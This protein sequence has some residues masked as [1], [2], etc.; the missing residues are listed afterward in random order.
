M[1]E[2]RM[3]TIHGCTCGPREYKMATECNKHVFRYNQT[4]ERSKRVAIKALPSR[5][6]GTLNDTWKFSSWPATLNEGSRWLAVCSNG[7]DAFGD[8][9]EAQLNERQLLGSTAASQ[10]LGRRVSTH[11]H[12]LSP[13]ALPS[14]FDEP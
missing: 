6:R 7:S 3:T 14:N 5:P 13:L 8:E 2:E 9:G 12:L 11:T 1:S 4:N 10:Y